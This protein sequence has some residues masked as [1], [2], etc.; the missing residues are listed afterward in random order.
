MDKTQYFELCEDNENKSNKRKKAKE[1]TRSDEKCIE[2]KTY[3]RLVK[4]NYNSNNDI[5]IGKKQNSKWG[6]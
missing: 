5:A 3:W 2:N 4:I 6:I 1:Q